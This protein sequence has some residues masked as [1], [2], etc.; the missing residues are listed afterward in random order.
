MSD[1]PSII[2]IIIKYRM[3]KIPTWC[4]LEVGGEGVRLGGLIHSSPPLYLPPL[5]P[6]PLPPQA[7]SIPQ[8]CL[9]FLQ[10][11]RLV[12][13]LPDLPGTAPLLPDFASTHDLPGG[14]EAE[15]ETGADG[16]AARR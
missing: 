16:A 4:N 13:V 9:P 1:K 11:G 14:T 3:Q 10:P 8:L 12:R 7:L 6:F 2:I 15:V 5:P